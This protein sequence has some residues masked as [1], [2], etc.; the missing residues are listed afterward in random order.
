VVRQNRAPDP[1]AA[2][3]APQQGSG[4]AGSVE[5]KG[6]ETGKENFLT[7]DNQKVNSTVVKDGIADALS[8]TRMRRPQ[9]NRTLTA[10]SLNV[11]SRLVDG[12]LN[13]ASGPVSAGAL[14]GTPSGRAKNESRE[15]DLS[16]LETRSNAGAATAET[17]SGATGSA[18]SLQAP[19]QAEAASVLESIHRMAEQAASRNQDR[20]SMT[21][22]FED[23]SSVRIRLVREGG[24]FHT[25]IHTDQPGM[26]TALRQ[27]WSQFSQDAGDRG[28]KFLS[29]SFADLGGSPDQH[30]SANG[31]DAQGDFSDLVAG[32]PTARAEASPTESETLGSDRSSTLST[33]GSGRLRAWV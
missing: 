2:R 14:L 33:S 6:S 16:A 29:M 1:E 26:E 3:I 20:L 32:V 17:R 11:N 21:L 31:E 10:A 8:G 22:R 7:S 4:N 13:L 28:F 5:S 18:T 25:V 9:E 15:I 23:G 24:E 27:Q 12:S 30:R 19:R